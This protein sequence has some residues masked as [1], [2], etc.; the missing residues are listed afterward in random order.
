[1]KIKARLFTIGILLIA[2]STA[3]SQAL[4]PSTIKFADLQ[5]YD[6][7]NETF[8]IEGY[9]LDIYHC[10]PCPPHA[11]CKPCIPDN[12]TLTDSDDWSN[13]SS[14]KRLRVYTERTDEFK[15]KGKYILT[16][17]VKGNL[18]AGK[19]VESV[20][21]V[22]SSGEPAAGTLFGGDWTGDSICTIR[23]SPCHDEHVI[24]RMTGPDPAGKLKVEMDKVVNGQ[25]EAMGDPLD[26]EF[27]NKES[28][29]NCSMRNGMWEFHVSGDKIEGTLTLPDGRLY[30]RINVLRATP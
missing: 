12:I 25:P 10:P 21:L 22:A 4:K 23:T 28:M 15:L 6:P 8:R 17:R 3:F 14:L 19:P 24:Y 9:V 11:M 18:Q 16:V 29:F 1:M 26:C 7:A 30:R 5:H 27:H 13:L 20:D 2:A